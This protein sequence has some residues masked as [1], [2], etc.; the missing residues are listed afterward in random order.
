[1]SVSSI[2]VFLVFFVF[3]VVLVGS[4]YC[5]HFCISIGAAV[6]NKFV[7]VAVVSSAMFVGSAVFCACVGVG[8]GVFGYANI[9]LQIYSHIFCYHFYGY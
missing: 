7:F 2:S 1:M 5:C 9:L 4:T 8:V 3:V 6:G